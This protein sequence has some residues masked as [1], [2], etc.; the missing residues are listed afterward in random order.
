MLV[1]TIYIARIDFCSCS[2][3]RV[4]FALASFCSCRSLSSNRSSWRCFWRASAFLFLN[5][6]RESE[7]RK[8]ENELEES[9]RREKRAKKYKSRTKAND[10]I[11]VVSGKKRRAKAITAFQLLLYIST[12]RSVQR[13]KNDLIKSHISR[14]RRV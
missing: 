12:D 3:L 14:Y 11:R 8:R 7:R 5:G 4:T 6:K 2:A 1:A 10:F 13:A 9:E